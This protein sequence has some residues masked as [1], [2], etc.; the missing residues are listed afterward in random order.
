MAAKSKKS[1]SAGRFG[2]RYGKRVRAKLVQVEIKQ[3]VKQKCP[4]CN[5]LGVKRL[6]KGIWQCT[7]KKCNKKFASDTYYLK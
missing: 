3:R 7:R 6:S 5:K 1:K 2:A 4:F